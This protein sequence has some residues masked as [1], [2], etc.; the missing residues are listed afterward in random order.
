MLI[1][2]AD[3]HE[4]NYAEEIKRLQ[5]ELIAAGN[6]NNHEMTVVFDKAKG[7]Y[8]AIIN[9]IIGRLNR[10]LSADKTTGIN[11]SHIE[12][13]TTLHLERFSSEYVNKVLEHFGHRYY[14]HVT[15]LCLTLDQPL[16]FKTFGLIKSLQMSELAEIT[17]LAEDASVTEK[18]EKQF[19]KF[20]GLF[21][22]I[23]VTINGSLQVLNAAESDS[24]EEKE[25]K[26]TPVAISPKPELGK[27]IIGKYLAFR[28]I[29]KDS[30]SIFSSSNSEIEAKIDNLLYL[31]GRLARTVSME[32]KKA[33][34]SAA[35]DLV[36][37]I[38]ATSANGTTIYL[39]NTKRFLENRDHG[40]DVSEITRQD[41]LAFYEN[42]LAKS[43]PNAQSLQ[44]G[45]MS[46]NNI[47]QI[48]LQSGYLPNCNSYSEFEHILKNLSNVLMR[49]GIRPLIDAKKL[50]IRE[51]SL[52][53]DR[54]TEISHAKDLKFFDDLLALVDEVCTTFGTVVSQEILQ[55]LLSNKE[56]SL[57]YVPYIL[58]ICLQL[59]YPSK[60]AATETTV[61]VELQA[62]MELLHHTK[63]DQ[64]N[65][66][67][68]KDKI[69]MIL[70][71]VLQKRFPE[72]PLDVLFQEF[73]TPSNLL[74]VPLSIEEATI[75]FEKYGLVNQHAANLTKLN[76][77]ELKQEIKSYALPITAN[78]EAYYRVLAIIREQVRRKFHIFPY[79]L[80]MI[81]VLTILNSS[82]RLAQI[83]TGEGKSIIIAMLAA[84]LALQNKKIDIITTSIDL[85]VR[86][87]RKF[88]PFYQALNLTVTH[89]TDKAEVKPHDYRPNIIYGTLTDFQF[90]Y[91]FEQLGTLHR[92]NRGQDTIII[93]EADHMT[94]E[95]QGHPAYIASV[96]DKY[97]AEL[98]EKI[99]L[100]VTAQDTILNPQSLYYYLL[101]EHR[102]KYSSHK[103]TQWIDSI[104][105][106]QAMH[107]YKNYAIQD[108]NIVPVNFEH[109]GQLLSGTRWQGGVHAFV[110]A[111]H[112]L[113]IHPED[114]CT[115]QVTSLE[116]F[117]LYTNIYGLT[118][119]LGNREELTESYH[120]SCYDSPPYFPSKK[121]AGEDIVAETPAEQDELILNDMQEQQR[122]GTPSLILSETIAQTHHY[123]N[124]LTSHG[125]RCQLYNGIQDKSAETLLGLSGN[126]KAI[127]VATNTAG[128]GADVVPTP[129]AE[130]NGGLNFI[131]T[132][133]TINRRVEIQNFGRT[134]RQ[135]RGGTFRYIFHKQ[136]LRHF[137]KNLPMPATSK[138]IIAKWKE[139][140]EENSKRVSLL[141]GQEK[142]F[143]ELEFIAQKMLFCLPK[144]YKL[145]KAIT[146][147]WKETYDEITKGSAALRR[148]QT[149]TQQDF[150]QARYLVAQQLNAFYERNNFGDANIPDYGNNALQF[151]LLQDDLK[152]TAMF[153]YFQPELLT[154]H[155]RL[156]NPRDFTKN[157]KLIAL[158]EAAIKNREANQK[159]IATF[160][161]SEEQKNNLREQLLTQ[162]VLKHTAVESENLEPVHNHE[163][164]DKE[165]EEYKPEIS[166]TKTAPTPAQLLGRSLPFIGSPASEAIDELKPDEES[167]ETIEAAPS[168]SPR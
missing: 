123:S 31:Y 129:K 100:F 48:E 18:I 92:Y 58:N 97:S 99:W 70:Q 25:E 112:G 90:D 19:K 16:E 128:R 95:A 98:Y 152:L 60:T 4:N 30:L 63:V 34:V 54:F 94:L 20:G 163:E 6:E 1:K 133:P 69:E 107:E 81:N 67:T 78:S 53:G 39:A 68:I 35:L 166:P 46:L 24:A 151:A 9:A 15:S 83:N 33:A 126:P 64:T 153:A 155:G 12:K 164:S 144:L 10:Y 66:T 101:M 74:E 49:R 57:A 135:G 38:K 59:S 87:T 43:F 71:A 157:E 77:R 119:T 160:V 52:L 113:K 22:G 28:K 65:W 143:F 147:D 150:N 114:F 26:P 159:S 50:S 61:N 79:N 111:E 165:E 73:T 13:I 45:L 116:Y 161:E 122:L 102:E 124:Y 41:A 103:I 109:T 134:G 29:M 2:L 141:R 106:A 168:N 82:R 139:L 23:R 7:G 117:N 80:Q 44:L 146:D 108:D 162:D 11:E 140:R 56:L 32:D 145:R 3:L 76:D 72:K 51:V 62:L 8:Y 93:D 84:T 21:A 136:Q 156:I 27:N 120:V 138:E 115:A 125:L 75:I 131:G 55:V 88:A 137:F 47:L 105:T 36:K 154:I 130:V 127:T 110:E 86:D 149:F 91:L 17:V 40:P 85:A 104:A 148:K 5:R 42:F 167:E 96:S 158:V 37:K 89:I 118:G 121:Q 14:Q 142:H 132:T